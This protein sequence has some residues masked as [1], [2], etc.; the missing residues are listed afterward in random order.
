MEAF[1]VRYVVTKPFEI[2]EL[3][4]CVANVTGQVTP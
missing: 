4:Q 2:E 3:I 1:G